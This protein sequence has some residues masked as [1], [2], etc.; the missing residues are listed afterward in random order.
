MLEVLAGVVM[1][2]YDFS[3]LLLWNQL[4]NIYIY[5]VAEI[6]VRMWWALL[7]RSTLSSD[8]CGKYN[9]HSLGYDAIPVFPL[10]F[11]FFLAE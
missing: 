6:L 11:K 2:C 3:L 9:V 1:S 4:L 5:F 8:A 7:K 10:N